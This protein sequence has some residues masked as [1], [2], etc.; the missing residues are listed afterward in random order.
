MP[1]DNSPD[2]R[3]HL[4]LSVMSL[5]REQGRGQACTVE[6]YERNGALYLFLYLDDYTETHVGQNQF[7]KLERKPLRSAF[8][9]VFVYNPVNGTLDLYAECDDARRYPLAAFERFAGQSTPATTLPP[10]T[11]V[12]LPTGGKLTAVRRNRL[13]ALLNVSAVAAVGCRPRGARF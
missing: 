1:Y 4:R 3:Q 2:A 11:A 6:P 8:E 10:A 12:R 9:V 13:G 7:G 5:Y